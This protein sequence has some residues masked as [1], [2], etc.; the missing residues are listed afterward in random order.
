M[1]IK[2]PFWEI[3]ERIRVGLLKLVLKLRHKP[4]RDNLN[5][6]YYSKT[7]YSHWLED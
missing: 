1:Y 3:L 7:F 4:A 2:L 5:L 6:D